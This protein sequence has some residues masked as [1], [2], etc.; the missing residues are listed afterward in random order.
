MSSENKA[1]LILYALQED[2]LD[3]GKTWRDFA[4]QSL[5]RGGVRVREVNT[6]DPK[7]NL[8]RLCES[9]RFQTIIV[10]RETSKVFDRPFVEMLF[11]KGIKF[12]YRGMEDIETMR[13]AMKMGVSDFIS[14]IAL[15]PSQIQRVISL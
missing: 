15:D 10:D 12:V 4:T 1:V 13:Q 14:N 11:S 9:G 8:L 2:K 6:L 7:I 3:Y 5:E